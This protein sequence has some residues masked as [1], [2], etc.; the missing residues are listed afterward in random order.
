MML[1]MT[2]CTELTFRKVIC[3][4]FT[5]LL[6]FQESIL[7]DTQSIVIDLQWYILREN[8]NP[9]TS[10]T[11]ICPHYPWQ[12]NHSTYDCQ[13]HSP[14]Q[15]TVSGLLLPIPIVAV[16]SHTYSSFPSYLIVYV[17]SMQ[18]QYVYTSYLIICAP[19]AVIKYWGKHDVKLNTP[20]N[21][22]ASLTLDQVEHASL[23][24]WIYIA[25]FCI[26]IVFFIATLTLDA[27]ET[28]SLDSGWWW[29]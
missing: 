15:P 12:M 6:H 2:D 29:L 25:T 5:P 3:R 13:R 4:K 19:V 10:P 1:M 11:S 18:C 9:S 14:L 22:S 23:V 16:S 28:M 26:I 8:P 20:M 17:N 21:S 24:A 27:F 7:I